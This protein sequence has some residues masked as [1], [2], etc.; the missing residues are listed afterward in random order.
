MS[1]NIFQLFMFIKEPS[2][3]FLCLVLISAS[4]FYST[5]CSNAFKEL[6]NQTSDDALLFQAQQEINL[7]QWS[8]AIN[9][10]LSTS[11]ASQSK[12]ES[13]YQLASAYAGRCGLDL[14]S[15][16]MELTDSLGANNLLP[17]L[18]GIMRTSTAANL[19]DCKL[20]EETVLS[21]HVSAAQRTEDENIL[22]AFIEF[23]KIGTALASSGIDS[24][25][26][27]ALGPGVEIWCSNNAAFL[28]N[29]QVKEV[30]TGLSILISSLTQVGGSLFSTVSSTMGPMCDTIDTM[31]GNPPVGVCDKTDVDDLDAN[32]VFA[33][34]SLIQAKELG[35][36][37]CNNNA[38]NHI[39]CAC[40]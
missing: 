4:I 25:D 40:P 17:A 35:F 15:M 5:G 27:G 2:C 22:L 12:R 10:I 32:A 18:L 29:A 20:A 39:D 14:V 28:T 24:N 8:N 7:R 3:R 6:S 9:T 23:A 30:G 1:K 31:L 34:R 13:K 36:N 33:L 21:I 16:S 26:D 11:P 19:D 37:R 38:I